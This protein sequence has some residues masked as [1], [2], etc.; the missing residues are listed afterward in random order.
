MKELQTTPSIDKDAWSPHISSL[1]P[2]SEFE[3]TLDVRQQR[4]CNGTTLISASE[5]PS[6][7]SEEE[8]A[9]RD[10]CWSGTLSSGIFPDL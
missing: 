3:S 5:A 2:L 6:W 1:L 8:A 9:R 4:P 10:V 7:G